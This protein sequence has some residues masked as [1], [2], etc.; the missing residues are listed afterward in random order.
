VTE[1]EPPRGVVAPVVTE[2][3]AGTRPEPSPRTEAGERWIARLLR[4]GALVSGTLFLG[5][6]ALEALPDSQRMGGLI[7]GLRQ[8]AASV[9]LVT[10]V[11]RLVVAG[12]ALGRRGEWRY[13]LVTAGVLGLMALAVGAGL[14]S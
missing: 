14:R 13:V 7:D 4:G 5:S 9:L 11:A 8:A 2:A 6:L 1:P 12:A 3:P 10:P